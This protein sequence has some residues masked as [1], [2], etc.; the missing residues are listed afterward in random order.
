VFFINFS[1]RRELKKII[2]KY[3][4]EHLHVHDL[5]LTKT[6]LQLKKRIPGLI[7]LDLHENY[8]ELLEGWFQAKKKWFIALKNKLLFTPKRWTKYEASVV[9]KV[10]KVIVVIDEMRDKFIQKKYTLNPE[11][12]IVV[13]NYEKKEFANHAAR[14]VDDGEF[15]FIQDVA[16]FVYVGGLEHMRG[17]E[18]VIDAVALLKER[19]EK[20][21]F[22]IV[23]S[24]SD[25]YMESLRLRVKNLKLE[26]E[27]LG[28][29]SFEV[30]NYYMQKATINIIP[31]IKNDHT[32]YTI[33][34]KLFQIFLSKSS[35]M[36]SSCKPLE[37]IV[38][39]CNGGWVFEA[40]SPKSIVENYFDIINHP[41]EI[42][43]R[44]LN[45]YNCA[46]TKY[47]WDAEALRLAKFYT[48]LNG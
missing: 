14:Q 18:T 15:D 42:E 2:K 12:V 16:H 23:G 32:D 35:L 9:P 11:N 39:E 10:D 29:K 7:I 26:N 19:N 33:P 47:N 21:K 34:H 4:I 22:L 48:E 13:S 3:N 27:V 5:P 38:K 6:A 40:S 31:H 28:Y 44:K 17:V 46:M 24:G 30:V 37:R 1:Y 43:I 8:P 25:V 20:I 45:A 41:E 36:V